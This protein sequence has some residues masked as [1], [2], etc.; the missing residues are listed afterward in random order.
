MRAGEKLVASDGY[1]VALFPLPYLYMTQDEGSDYSHIG[2]YN[3]DLSGW[4]TNGKIY[5]API[6]APCTMKVIYTGLTEA[7][8]NQVGFQSVN[9]VHLANGE[10]D[11]LCIIFSHDS[12]PPITTIGQVVQQGELCYHTGTYGNVT[13]DHVHTC[14]GMGVWQGQTQRPPQNRWDLTNR[15]HYWDALYVNDT[16][17][18]QGYNHNWIKWNGT[19]PTF[20][21]RNKFPWV[22]YSNKLRKKSQIFKNVK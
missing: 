21:K 14:T 16:I 3:I 13:G 1:E 20:I 10:L 12:N 8:G 9:K 19:S 18:V 15:I 2:T 6:Y 11:Y 22:L 4:G 7:G 5:N 17:I